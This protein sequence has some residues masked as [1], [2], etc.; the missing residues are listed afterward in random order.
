MIRWEPLKFDLTFSRCTFVFNNSVCRLSMTFVLAD[1]PDAFRPAEGYSE[2]LPWPNA[3]GESA[4]GE[5][6]GDLGESWSDNVLCTAALGIPDIR[7]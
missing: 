7:I 5:L 2:G 4:W 1:D 3:V 6:R